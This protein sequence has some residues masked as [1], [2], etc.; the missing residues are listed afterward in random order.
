MQYVRKNIQLRPDQNEAIRKISF[1]TRLS[2]SEIIRLALDVYLDSSNKEA[3]PMQT[4]T[5]NNRP[6]NLDD[7]AHYMD[8]EIRES[9][10]TDLAP[11]KSQVFLDEYCKRHAAKHGEEFR[12]D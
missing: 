11:C 9:V 8:D 7:I 5:L 2:E 12:V 10:H 6:V 3:T 1:E 4:A